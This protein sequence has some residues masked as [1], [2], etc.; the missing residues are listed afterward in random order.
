MPIWNMEGLIMFSDDVTRHYHGGADTSSAAWESGRKKAD[1]D[2]KQIFAWIQ[3]TGGATCEECER[4]LKLKHQTCSARITQL[5]ADGRIFWNG[6][7]KKTESG[8]NARIYEALPGNQGRL[9]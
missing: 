9:L 1:A 8:S 4:A 7:F 5:L 6:R 2:R 3:G